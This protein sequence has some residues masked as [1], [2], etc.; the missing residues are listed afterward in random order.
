[1]TFR[2]GPELPRRRF[3]G[4]CGFQGEEEFLVFLV[5]SGRY[6]N[7][8]VAESPEVG[9]VSNEKSFSGK[10]VSQRGRVPV[11]IFDSGEKECTRA[12]LRSESGN[13]CNLILKPLTFLEGFSGRRFDPAIDR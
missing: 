9:A 7:V 3:G 6:A 2:A 1:M 12:G 8:V 10:L 11:R 5:N 4:E 13:A